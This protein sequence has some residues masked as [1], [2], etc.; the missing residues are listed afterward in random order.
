[1]NSQT[2]SNNFSMKAS[3]PYIS[4]HWSPHISLENTD[5]LYG[6]HSLLWG[7][8]NFLG[9]TGRYHAI[10]GQRHI[11]LSARG[12]WD[13]ER[14]TDPNSALYTTPLL[15]ASTRLPT[16]PVD[17]SLEQPNTSGSPLIFLGF[18]WTTQI[19]GFAID[20]MSMSAQNSYVEAYRPARWNLVR[21]AAVVM[22]SAPLW[23]RPQTAPSPL[24]P[25]ED[26]GKESPLWSRKQA[27][28]GH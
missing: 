13:G 19:L 27:L 11:D 18:A 28:T 9:Q 7:N 1:M 21:P 23:K 6:P 14:V 22:R 26:M 2:S 17:G 24:Q 12:G 16:D 8:C 3:L 10:K 25:R 4:E 5:P 15:R 20:W